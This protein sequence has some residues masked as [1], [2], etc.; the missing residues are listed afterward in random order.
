M[1]RVV[2]RTKE[3]RLQIVL[4]IAKR[5]R[6]FPT[7]DGTRTVDLYNESYPAIAELK[8]VFDEYIK[9]HQ[10]SS[11]AGKIRFPEINKTIEYILPAKTHIEPLFVLRAT[12]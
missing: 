8:T 7:T 10:R 1:K 12:K 9:S 2:L 4:N 3:D 6:N 5:L 11:L